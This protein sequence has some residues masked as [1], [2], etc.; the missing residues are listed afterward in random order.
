MLYWPPRLP[1]VPMTASTARRWRAVTLTVL[2]AYGPIS[3]DLYLPSL[4]AMQH[5]LAS[6]IAG[7]QL[8]LSAF[9][10]G[11]AVAQLVYGPLS[12]RYG[13]RPVLLAG[14]VLYLAASLACVAATTLDALVA[15]R[16]VQALGACAGPVLARAVVRDLHGPL[17][18][19]RVLAYMGT[20]MAVVPAAAPSLGGLLE[21]AFG[22]RANFVALALFGL[23]A[24]VLTWFALPESHLARDP[25]AL[26]PAQIARNF[27]TLLRHRAYLGSTLA[28]S[29]AFAGLF[30]FISGSPFVLI[31]VLGLPPERFGLGFL[32]A[33]AG[34]M[35]GSFL[36]GRLVRR[37]GT[38][39]LVTAGCALCFAGGSAMTL[40]ALSGSATLVTL[41]GT[42]WLYFTGA[43]LAIPVGFAAALAPF[44]GMAGAA[45][46]LLGFVQMGIGG[47]AGM[48]VGHLYD[49]TPGPMALGMMLGGGLALLACRLLYPARRFTG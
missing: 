3:T 47:L 35:G 9:V 4:P 15:W 25:D 45:S 18:A 22:W 19:G 30:C 27:A 14:L 32:V 46:S 2:V 31:E 13:R 34:F 40:V 7:V 33:V 36:S 44:P 8:T 1:G 38:P 16:F 43:G 17:D 29:A 48:A 11:F 49:G 28:V 24:L 12:D 42:C 21:V 6:D 41:L 39:R 23:L 5:A 37:L 26:R 10:W 20:A